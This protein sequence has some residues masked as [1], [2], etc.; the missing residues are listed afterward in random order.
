MAAS[1]CRSRSHAP[2]AYLTRRG[3]LRLGIGLGQYQTHDPTISQYPSVR[4]RPS[5]G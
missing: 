4:D 2:R 1:P 3:D 5:F